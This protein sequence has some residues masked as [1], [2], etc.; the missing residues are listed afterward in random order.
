MFAGEKPAAAVPRRADFAPK[1][2]VAGWAQLSQKP[3]FTAHGG[4][5]LAV[6]CALKSN[7]PAG[8][9]TALARTANSR[10]FLPNVLWTPDSTYIATWKGFDNLALFIDAHAC[11][12][13]GWRISTIALAGFVL[14]ALEHAVHD[15]LPGKGI[16]LGH[17][18]E[19]LKAILSHRCS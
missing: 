5:L 15:C 3:P 19:G 4:D 9:S 13:G 1:R 10:R 8:I 12:I 17:H 16:G 11:K 18:S 6:V 2:Q 14:D 7:S